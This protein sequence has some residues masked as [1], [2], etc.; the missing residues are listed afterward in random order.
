[1]SFMSMTV[2]K[3]PVVV[4]I[5]GSPHSD[6]ALSWAIDE[7][8]LRERPLRIVHAFPAMVS[9][10]G[11]TAHEY[12]PQ[13]EQEARTAFEKALASAPAVDGLDVERDLVRGSPAE[14]LVAASREANLLVVGSRGLGS[15]RGM[16]LGS[17][18]MHCV[19]QAHC[20]VVVVRNDD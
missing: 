3:E 17:V 6:V 5:D 11:T 19:N 13:V 12:Y 2:G 4:G 15:F 18:S 16:L 8:R 9:L 1:M 14:Q 7:A 10:V 20:P